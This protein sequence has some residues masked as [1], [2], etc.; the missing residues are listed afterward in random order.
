MA[1]Q[2]NYA[3]GS[4]KGIEARPHML[5][6][7]EGLERP[8]QPTT[9]P[10]Q[11]FISFSIARWINTSAPEFS[12]L[13]TFQQQLATAN[14]AHVPEPDE[15]RIFGPAEAKAVNPSQLHITDIY[16]GDAH[17][18][19]LAAFGDDRGKFRQ[20]GK[21]RRKVTSL[22]RQYGEM[23]AQ[24]NAHY[25][26]LVESEL[27]LHAPQTD[28]ETTEQTLGNTALR[29]LSGTFDVEPDL[30]GFGVGN[31]FSFIFPEAEEK[32]LREQRA[33]GLS[34][35]VDK[36]KV[37]V[38]SDVE[39]KILSGQHHAMVITKDIRRAEDPYSVVHPVDVD[40]QRLE[41][42]RLVTHLD[43][44]MTYVGEDDTRTA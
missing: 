37:Q 1:S 20:P 27:G 40:G 13:S 28:S 42:P 44:K 10:K 12:E 34:F 24:K 8:S 41:T 9:S 33:T 39:D 35:V 26:A 18:L 29:L 15:E 7:Q 38:D 17:Q 4:Y 16:A 6:R 19:L 23:I 43:P 25:V 30:H 3:Y 11:P 5:P 22:K 2:V 21:V 31:R 32:F 36:L 14:N